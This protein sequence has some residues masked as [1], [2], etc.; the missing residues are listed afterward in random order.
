LEILLDS[1]Y[2]ILDGSQPGV[3]LNNQYPVS[4]NFFLHFMEKY[5]WYQDTKGLFKI[6]QTKFFF[7]ATADK[8]D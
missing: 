2:W 7:V 8:I 3:F 4:N 6:I 1:G 5:F